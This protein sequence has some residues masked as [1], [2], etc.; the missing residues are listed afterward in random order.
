MAKDER[1]RPVL[2]SYRR[3]PYAMRARLALAHARVSYEIREID[4]AN[5]PAC[6]LKRSPKGTVPVLLIDKQTHIDESLDIVKWAFL[7]APESLTTAE[8]KKQQQRIGTIQK[9][10]L[11][12]YPYK[13]PE[14]YSRTEVEIATQYLEIFTQQL[15]NHLTAHPQGWYYRPFSQAEINLLPF[16]RQYSIAGQIDW[17]NTLPALAQWYNDR[18]ENIIFKNIM[19]KYPTW[20]HTHTVVVDNTSIA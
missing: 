1:D 4:L 13:Y 14:R 12:I 15:N 8:R 2:Y 7:R 19:H 16:I 10:V 11:S 9:F 6:M 20:T 3:C 17:Q 18:T 5:K